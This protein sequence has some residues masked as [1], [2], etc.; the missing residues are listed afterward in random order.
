LEHRS[1]IHGAASTTP[2]VRRRENV[3]Q[4]FASTSALITGG[5]RGI[6]AAVARRLAP[7]GASVTI[8]YHTN[9]DR[10]QSL[11]A[12][13]TGAGHISGSTLAAD[14]AWM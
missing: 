14:G 5:S 13:L 9:A 2:A 8:T 10:A 7:E 4:R 12:E 11:V 6:G 3:M 1:L